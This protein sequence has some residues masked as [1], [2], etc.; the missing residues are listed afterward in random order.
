MVCLGDLQ[1]KV[2]VVRKVLGDLVSHFDF[3]GDACLRNSRQH[4]DRIATR[5]RIKQQVIRHVEEASRIVSDDHIQST[6]RFTLDRV[7][8]NNDG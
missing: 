8:G 4:F 2:A 5:L 1:D 7:L 6:E 3:G